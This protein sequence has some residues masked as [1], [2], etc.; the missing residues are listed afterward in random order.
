MSGVNRVREQ[1]RKSRKER[2]QEIGEVQLLED[3]KKTFENDYTLDWFIPRGL[4]QD[5]VESFENNIYSVI[6][7]PSGCGKTTTALWWALSQ[8]RMRKYNQLI[9]I[10]NP[11]EVGDDQIGF[12]S[13]SEDDKLTAHYD[14]TKHIFYDFIS[15]NK[16]ENDVSKRRIRLTIPNFLLGS[17]F[18]NA[19][20]IVDETQTMSPNTVKL[21]TERCGQDTKYILLG[22]SSQTYSVKKRADGFKDFMER[23]TT[24]QHDARWSKCNPYVGYVK[25]FYNDNQRSEGSK[26]INKLYSDVV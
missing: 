10:K 21:L 12:L 22:D 20:V 24:T 8:I 9:F 11:T 1:Q 13:G 16:L 4:Q 19:I 15:K 25:M 18:D 23:T 14:T 5:C 6:D 2:R 3:K 17:T 26:F 7:A